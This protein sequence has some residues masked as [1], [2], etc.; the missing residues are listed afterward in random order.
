LDF[1]AGI[2]NYVSSS[3][4]M[5]V[6]LITSCPLDIDYSVDLLRLRLLGY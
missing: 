2:M 1:P 5:R 3:N 4:K 6:R